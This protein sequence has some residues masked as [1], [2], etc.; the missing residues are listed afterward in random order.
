MQETGVRGKLYL[1]QSLSWGFCREG[2]GG[3]GEQFRL[4]S[5]NYFCGLLA[6]E[7]VYSCLVPGPGMRR[8]R[9]VAPW[10]LWAIEKRRALH[11]LV[12][13]SKTHATF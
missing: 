1:D 7:V 4:A 13:L 2:T 9:K 3:Q 11:C 10:G 5:L 8:E 12:C 6:T